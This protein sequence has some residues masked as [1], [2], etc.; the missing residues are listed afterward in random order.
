MT[1]T[2]Y[3]SVCHG[4][5][6]VMIQ[7]VAGQDLMCKSRTGSGKTLAFAIPIIEALDRQ[8]MMLL[9]DTV[10]ACISL[11]CNCLVSKNNGKEEVRVVIRFHHSHA[12]VRLDRRS[13]LRINR[14]IAGA[15]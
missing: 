12:K 2:N 4:R 7:V 1:T 8:V 5:P 13:G 11:K 15:Q 3:V 6:L 14:V 9:Y 10:D